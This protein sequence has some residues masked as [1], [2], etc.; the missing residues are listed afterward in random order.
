[1]L[2]PTKTGGFGHGTI[3]MLVNALWSVEP[4]ISNICRQIWD[5]HPP[6]GHGT[7]FLQLAVHGL[8]SLVLIMAVI[9]SYSPQEL[10]V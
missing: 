4:P 3:G 8:V 6:C 7:S 1:M 10:M 9:Q 5:G 2:V